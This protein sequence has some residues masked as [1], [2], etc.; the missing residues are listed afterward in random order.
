MIDDR[1]SDELI[2]P[3]SDV[4]ASRADTRLAREHPA[5]E[6]I[7]QYLDHAKAC[8]ECG[9]KAAVLEWLYFRSPAWTWEQLVGREGWLTICRSCHHQV[10]FFVV[11]MN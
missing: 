8:S 5:G 6:G 7:A 2:F 10:D 3:W 11:V 1:D 9:A 4:E